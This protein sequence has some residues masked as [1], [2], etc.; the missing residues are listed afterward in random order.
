[1]PKII[2][3]YATLKYIF[4]LMCAKR[5]LY[6]LAQSQH[7]LPLIFSMLITDV[8]SC[9]RNPFRAHGLLDGSYDVWYSR[10]FLGA[11]FL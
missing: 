10:S 2:G 3:W 8:I 1:M 4:S 7:S 11:R 5:T 6:R 9:L